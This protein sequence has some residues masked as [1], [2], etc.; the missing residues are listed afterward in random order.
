M[1]TTDTPI[2]EPA[3]V[4]VI[5]AGYVGLTTSVCLAHF[6]HSVCCGEVNPERV[7]LLSRGEPTIVEDGLRELLG[8]GL[9]QGRLRFVVGAATSVEDAEFVFLCLPTPQNTDGSANLVALEFAVK[10]I[11]PFLAHGAV[12]VNKSTVPVGAAAL[13][14]RLLDRPDV[15]VV[16]NPE[17]LREGTA[18]NDSL[19]PDRIVVGSDDPPAAARVAELFSPTGAPQLRTDPATAE[20]IKY[21]SNAF[22]ATKLGFV[23]S[24]TSVCEALGANIDDV[25]SGMGQ[26]RRIGFGHLRPGPGWGGSCLPKDTMALATTARAAGRPFGILEEVIRSNRA[27]MDT[28]VD[29]IR[30]MVGGTVVD[31][32][33]CVWGLSFKSG[34]DDRRD[35]PAVSIVRA[36]LEDRAHVH[37]YDPTTVGKEV[38]ELASRV[39]IHDDLYSACDK[40]DV[41]VVLTEW[42]EFRAADFLKVRDLLTSPRIVD[43]RNHLDTRA[44]WGLGFECVALGRPR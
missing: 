41:L 2:A 42:E 32:R 19:K 39:R 17:F 3:R 5:G 27:H 7:A 36:L 15:A 43:A 13:I 31:K 30:A 4:A 22:L 21:A 11:A 6:G 35:S 14:S 29:K 23:N 12:V 9:R 1:N 37:A 24:L 34:T 40:A 16:S 26:D 25:L 28:V 8:E 10:E 44:L 20:M 38:P 18:I 33:V